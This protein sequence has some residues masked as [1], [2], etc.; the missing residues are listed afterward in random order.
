M[1]TKQLK[2]VNDLL[3]AGQIEE[4]AAMLHAMIIACK[5]SKQMFTLHKFAHSSVL[6]NHPLFN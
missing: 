1:S 3:A 5:T 4:A 6:A 2:I